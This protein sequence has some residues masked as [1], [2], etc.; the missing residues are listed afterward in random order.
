MFL[1]KKIIYAKKKNHFIKIINQ[2]D[3]GLLLLKNDQTGMLL[4]ASQTNSMLF[5]YDE[6]FRVFI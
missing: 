3:Y 6:K 5:N 2:T 1:E 4:I